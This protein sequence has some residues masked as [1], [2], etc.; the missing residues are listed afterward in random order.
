MCFPS[1]DAVDQWR[2]I[3]VR[4]GSSVAALLRQPLIRVNARGARRYH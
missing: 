4:V 1:R 2:R 3:D